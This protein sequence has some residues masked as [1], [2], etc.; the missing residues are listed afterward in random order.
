MPICYSYGFYPI[1]NITFLTYYMKIYSFGNAARLF[2]KIRGT[3]YISYTM[4]LYFNRD[5]IYD[6]AI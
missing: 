2:F 6:D 1:K 5:T 3:Q 4:F